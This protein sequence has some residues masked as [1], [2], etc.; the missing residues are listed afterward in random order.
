MYVF[1]VN[2]FYL[3]KG[4]VPS[5]IFEDKHTYPFVCTKANLTGQYVV[6]INAVPGTKCVL[7]DKIDPDNVSAILQLIIC[8]TSYFFI[9]H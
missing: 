4:Y 3:Q 2:E 6:L 5:C 9:K 7:D 8:K 1:Q